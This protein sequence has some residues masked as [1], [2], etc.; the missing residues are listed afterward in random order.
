MRA[1]GL[2]RGSRGAD[3]GARSPGTLTG[4]LRR[5]GRGG[6]AGSWR[7]AATYLLVRDPLRLLQAEGAAK[8]AVL[9]HHAQAARGAHQ[10]LGVATRGHLGRHDAASALASRPDPSPAKS[11]A[12]PAWM[13]GA[14]S[15]RH[16]RLGARANRRSGSAP[17]LR[18]SIRAR[19][20]PRPPCCR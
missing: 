7:A 17:P 6:G 12:P 15:N 19:A 16:A 5:A 10:L 9:G 2:G 8:G 20:P 4:G 11:P 1:L 18:S 14:A 13:T 3:K